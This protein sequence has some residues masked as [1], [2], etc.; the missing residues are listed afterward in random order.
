[1]I[2]ECTKER[3]IEDTKNHK[4]TIKKDDGLYRHLHL[5]AGSCNQYYEIITYPDGLMIRGDMGSYVFERIED[6]FCFFRDA[7]DD[8]LS[9]N[10]GYWAE[11]VTAESVFGNGIKEFSS[12]VF[13]EAVKEE[14]EQYYEGVPD[15]DPEKM[16]VWEEIDSQVLSCDDSEWDCVSRL[17]DFDLYP[18]KYFDEE[19][20]YVTI[21]EGKRF[22]FCDF[23]ENSCNVKTYNYVWCLYAIVFAIRLYDEVH[24]EKK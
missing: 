10:T 17:N 11:K 13:R 22:D 15:N 4:L 21:P 19:E 14:F 12:D 6:M 3:F 7:K 5:S 23:W 24:N 2:H 9:I 20:N 8:F 18:Y 16:F 1:M